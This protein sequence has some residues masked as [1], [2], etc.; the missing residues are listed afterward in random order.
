MVRLT[1]DVIRRKSEHNEGTM[2][3]LEE[4]AL[5]Q[6]EI[7][8]IEAIG[9]LCRRLRILYLQNN[10]IGKMENLKHLKELEYLNLALNNITKI[11][12][13]ES[14][15]SLRKLDLTVNFVAC[16]DLEAS[17]RNLQC[18]KM[19]RELYVVGNPFS[20]WDG[21]KD[22]LCAMLPWLVKIDG[23]D[24]TKAERIR[25]HQR[26]PELEAE[27]AGRIAQERLAAMAA[28]A[29]KPSGSKCT[30]R[31]ADEEEEGEK[32]EKG[33]CDEL[34]RDASAAAAS[35][36]QEEE[37]NA[38]YT[39]ELRT[40]MYREMAEEKAEKEAREK[41]RM[42]RE[43]NYSHEHGAAVA[44]A[45]EQQYFGD[46][47]VRQCNEGGLRFA[48]DED[49]DNFFFEVDLPRHADT[50]LVDCEVF[51]RFVQVIFKDKTLRVAVPGG[52]DEEVRADESRCERSKAS[53]KLTVTMPKVNAA[54]MV[55]GRDKSLDEAGKR[56][57]AETQPGRSRRLASAADTDKGKKAQQ[58]LSE[59]VDVRRVYQG[60][61]NPHLARDKENENEK[62]NDKAAPLMQVRSHTLLAVKQQ[63]E[64]EAA[65]AVPGLSDDD[66]DDDEC[67]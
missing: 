24:I 13:L 58:L 9:P 39:P 12:G 17:A 18:N 34:E 62:E 30:I 57:Q 37:E 25:A 48:F 28:M 7:E 45:Y 21:H 2:A 66:D 29:A 52:D 65:L 6:L 55:L 19:L 63:R 67:E 51:P 27:L 20:D 1:A 32:G 10:I 61:E 60:K 44:Q 3:D 33:E 11:E 54:S 15:E 56:N 42:P 53:G 49:P 46:G 26:M 38:P 16:A 36:E 35:S 22:Y 43:R 23:T 41:E 8:R 14:C 4:I 50:S 59:A 31:E 40:E 64:T 5:H 47:R